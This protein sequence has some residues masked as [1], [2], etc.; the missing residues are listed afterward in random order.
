MFAAGRAVKYAR[1][2]RLA[3]PSRAQELPGVKTFMDWVRA[4]AK[5]FTSTRVP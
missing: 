1:S 3:C 2:Y 4:E 5:L